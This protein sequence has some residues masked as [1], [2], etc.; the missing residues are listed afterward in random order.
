MEYL[1]S[2]SEVLGSIPSIERKVCLAESSMLSISYT[3]NFGFWS[4][5]CLYC[6]YALAPL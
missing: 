4:K 6:S 3:N 2:M 1:L 5:T